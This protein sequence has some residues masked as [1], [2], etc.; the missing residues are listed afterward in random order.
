MMARHAI[1]FTI[2]ASLSILPAS[3]QDISADA[4]PFP[5]NDLGIWQAVVDE[6]NAQTNETEEK[7]DQAENELTQA[8]AIFHKFNKPLDE[9][10][11]LEELGS[12]YTRR[13]RLPE[14]EKQYQ[15][16]LTLVEN[17]TV[18]EPEKSKLS[19]SK[20]RMLHNE[21]CILC[22]LKRY[23]AAEPLFC[24]SLHWQ[25]GVTVRIG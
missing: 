8:L 19:K 18:L 17:S 7:Y 3:A 25:K 20:L 11:V 1:V 23:S 15:Q 5:L 4:N 24:K 10:R 21:A 12:I 2:L 13:G 6:R 16:A 14:A 9:V 22:L